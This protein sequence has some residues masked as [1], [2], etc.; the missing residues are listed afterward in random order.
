MKYIKPFNEAESDKLLTEEDITDYFLEFIDNDSMEFWFNSGQPSGGYVHMVYKLNSKF[1]LI[2][3]TEDLDKL[4]N[5]IKKISETCKRWKLKFQL[6]LYGQ[7]DDD[8]NRHST[9]SIIQEVPE[10][11]KGMPHNFI[12]IVGN[13]EYRFDIFTVIN[14]ESEFISIFSPSSG[15]TNKT[16]L[17]EA[18]N[19][20]EEHKEEIIDYIE[21][22]FTTNCKY[23]GE[24]E[25]PYRLYLDLPIIEYEFKLEV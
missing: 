8:E 22:N 3:N 14:N 1:I 11:I 25:N 9:I 2:E 6:D 23:I 24:K 18:F 16:K 12:A 15:T 17:K 21:K 5:L 13:Y 20:F 4:S 7:E 10:K 19:K